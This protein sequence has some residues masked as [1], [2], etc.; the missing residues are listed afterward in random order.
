VLNL[1]WREH[2]R[3]DAAAI[4]SYIAH[5]NVAAAEALQASIQARAERLREHPF[6]HRPG[7]LPGTR[8]AV[9]HRN[10]IMVYR[11]TDDAVEIVNLM[12]ARRQ[13]P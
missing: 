3:E 9:V 4:F 1:I 10:Y 6:L 13:Y 11:V 5:R 2:A 8:E 7:R 12:H